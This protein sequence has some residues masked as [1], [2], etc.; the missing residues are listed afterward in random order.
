VAKVPRSRLYRVTPHGLRV[1][2]A[3]IAMHDDHYPSRYL[4]AA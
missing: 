4:A 3:V 1:M 2:T